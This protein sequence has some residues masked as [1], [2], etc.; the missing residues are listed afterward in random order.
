MQLGNVGLVT[1]WHRRLK[2]LNPQ[3]VPGAAAHVQAPAGAAGR[4]WR[5]VQLVDVSRRARAIPEL[6][7]VR[8]PRTLISSQP[9]P[10]VHTEI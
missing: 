8:L 7:R 6:V 10:R 3:A 9:V 5:R 4:S 1:E 2:P